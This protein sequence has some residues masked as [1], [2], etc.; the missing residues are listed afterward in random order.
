MTL[1]QL[2][3]PIPD[4]ALC[5]RQFVR[6]MALVIFASLWEAHH[7]IVCDCLHIQGQTRGS[8]SVGTTVFVCSFSN[9]LGSKTNTNWSLESGPL[10]DAACCGLQLLCFCIFPA[11]HFRQHVHTTSGTRDSQWG[12][13]PSGMFPFVSCLLEL[14]ET[15]HKPNWLL[16]WA[17]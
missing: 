12:L 16:C 1:C 15:A 17:H 11:G 14:N 5:R 2:G 3:L 6:I 13:K 9:L 8:D 7:C 4:S 10:C